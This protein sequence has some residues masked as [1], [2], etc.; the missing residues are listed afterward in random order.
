MQFSSYNFML[1]F[2]PFSIIAYYLIKRYIPNM[3]KVCLIAVS[4]I[5]YGFGGA[6]SS[7]LLCIDIVANYIISMYLVKGHYK[8]GALTVG[9]LF[10]ILVLIYFKYFFAMFRETRTI[11]SPLGLSFITFQQISFLVDLY[12]GEINNHSFIDYIVYITFFPKIIMGPIV[13]YKD[14]IVQLNDREYKSIDWNMSADGT[15]MFAL[16]LFKKICI[17]DTFARLVSYGF[18]NLY[19]LSSGDIVVIMFAYTFQIYFDFSGYSDMAVGIAKLLNIV[20]PINFDSP[21]KAYS[22]RGFWDRWHISLSKFFKKYVYIPLGGNRKGVI[23]TY[24]NVLAVFLIS[25]IWHGAN[26]TFLL[27]GLLHGIINIIERIFTKYLE[28]VNKAVRWIANLL[29]ISVL[30]LLFRSDSIEQWIYLLKTMIKFENIKVSAGLLSSVGLVNSEISNMLHLNVLDGYIGCFKL[31]VLFS[32]GLF[33]C[34]YP[35]NCYKRKYLKKV[36]TVVMTSILFIIS[37]VNMS[38]GTSFIYLYF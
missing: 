30:W 9:I 23:R 14:I 18:N 33:L 20:F 28:K 4:L 35:E 26:L 34:L 22:L 10:N 27:W 25:G 36:R 7:I 11:A 16:G 15:Q 24:I 2:L 21:Y 8:K 29:C 6:V 19:A 12:R 37:L 32:A 3:Q 13:P 17:A 1:F 31:I 5:F 38:Q